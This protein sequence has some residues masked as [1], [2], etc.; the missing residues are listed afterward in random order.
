VTKRGHEV[1]FVLGSVD[2]PYVAELVQVCA[3][4]DSPQTRARELRGLEEA[5]TELEV[6]RATIVTLREAESLTTAAGTVDVVPAWRWFLG[7]A[8]G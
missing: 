6:D 4:L 1:D 8:V 2:E 3:S 7:T 5:M